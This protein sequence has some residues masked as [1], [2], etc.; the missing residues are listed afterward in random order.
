M[1]RVLFSPKKIDYPLIF[2]LLPLAFLYGGALY[3]RRLFAKPKD[4]GVKIVSIGN[5]VIGGSGKTPF[6]IE[7]INY[8]EAKGLKVGYLSRGY[9]RESKGLVAVKE[10]GEIVCDVR[11][12]GDEAMVVAK[13]CGCEVVVSE[14]RGEG[15]EYLK[16][17]G[18][19]LVILDDG[20]S[21]VNIKKFDILL[22]PY[23]IKNRFPLPAGG[24]REFYFTKKYANLVL[25]EGRDF[26]R[27][28]RVESR[29]KDR[30]LL[31]TAIS[32]PQRLKRYLPSNVVGSYYL[33]DHSFFDKEIIEKKMKEVGANRILSTSKD[34]VKLEEFKL[35]IEV[36]ELKL[37]INLEILREIE[38]FVDEKED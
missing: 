23:E 13:E 38:R 12:C 29:D 4:F 14:D 3:L 37:H 17:R 10:G 22:E 25:K 18:V 24:L 36:L 21:K 32:K 34:F 27:E 7:L 1:E 26:K 11:R 33:S 5:L 8:F 31:V 9:K 28:V 20:F 6:A 16:R 30:F 35:D 15:I 19:D 2:S